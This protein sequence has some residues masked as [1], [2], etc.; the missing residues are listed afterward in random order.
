MLFTCLR[1][2]HVSTK[3]GRVPN[4]LAK[5]SSWFI[6][7]D[8][9]VDKQILVIVFLLKVDAGKKKKTMMQQK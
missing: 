9:Q 7:M 4:N 1:F 3:L 8:N 2:C 6:D 5:R